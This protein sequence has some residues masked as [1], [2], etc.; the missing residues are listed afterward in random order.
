M[1][2]ELRE[3]SRSKVEHCA[4]VAAKREGVH[5]APRAEECL[6]VD[7]ARLSR[8]RTRVI[9]A[10]GEAQNDRQL[11]VRYRAQWITLDH[12]AHLGDRLIEG[13]SRVA[14]VERGSI[15]ARL[16]VSRIDRERVV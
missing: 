9:V 10:A 16:G 1:A 4:R 7:L 13:A 8:F 5:L 15:H 6:R 12:R 2:A 11:R 14:Q 3:K